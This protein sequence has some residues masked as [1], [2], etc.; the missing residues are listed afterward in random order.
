LNKAKPLPPKK[1]STGKKRVV[2]TLNPN[3]QMKDLSLQDNSGADADNE[4]DDDDEEDIE[5]SSEAAA[6]SKIKGFEDSYK[7]L[8]NHKSIIN[9]KN[10]DSIL[11][12]AFTAQLKGDTAYA[13]NCVI[14]SLMIQ[15][16]G[17]LGKD[18]L[19]VFF[20]R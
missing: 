16:V 9:E 8:Q 6:F 4:D 2:E 7:Y 19:N 5:M 12:N 18:G 3:A 1:T 10:A 13:K 17:Q 15:Y 11:G 20:A 14:Q